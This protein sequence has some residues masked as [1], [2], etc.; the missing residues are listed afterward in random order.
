MDCPHIPDLA[1]SDFNR[2]LRNTLAG[3]RFPISGSLELT[4]RCNMRCQHCYV[5]HGHAGIPGKQ[6]LSTAEIKNLFDQLVDAGCL[7][8]LISGGEPLVRRD[9]ADIWTFAKQK[10]LLPTLFTNGT[11][12]TPFL[13]DFLAEYRPFNLEITLYG[14]TQETYE[15][16]TG[17]PG[18][19]ARCLRGI[20][21]LQERG[22]P[23]RLKTV[24]ITLNQHELNEMQALADSLGLSFRYDAMINAGVDRSGKPLGLRLPPSQI[25][26]LDLSDK[27]RMPDW[28]SFRERIKGSQHDP[29]QL[30][31][32]G[33][34]VH[35]F[36]ID[37]YGE[38]S[39]CMMSRQ[40]SYDLRRG[41]FQQGWDD[42]LAAVRARPASP[43][44]T[45]NSCEL[46]PMCGQCP[47][48][49]YME[50]GDEQKKVNFLCQ[51]AHR[52]ANAFDAQQMGVLA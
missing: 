44:Y 7:W 48:W 20:D 34:G 49:A 46:L 40:Q 18:S 3:G 6:E 37:P 12:L 51:V 39:L 50:H 43:A 52:R 38:L 9:F 47:G 25:V 1:Y 31:A 2:R 11:L 10:G 24:V 8:L 15:R 14:A 35:S 13:A 5:A 33:A 45:C 36:H 21:L 27:R 41:T 42:F 32:C 19:Y 30:Y 4:F 26:Q 23:L 29:A 22:L 28:L 16:V 17:I